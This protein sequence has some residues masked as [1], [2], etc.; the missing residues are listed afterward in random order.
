MKKGILVTFT[1]LLVVVTAAYYF[2]LFP[3]TL[4][5]NIVVNKIPKLHLEKG[6]KINLFN[7]FN[8]DEGDYSLYVIFTPEDSQYLGVS[9]VLYTDDKDIL[10]KA[11]SVL[12]TEYTGGDVATCDSYLY[13]MKEDTPVL[14]MGLSIHNNIGGL[15]SSEYGWIEF[16]DFNGVYNLLHQ[17][18]SVYTPILKI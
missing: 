11:Q 9:K 17:L 14:K 2:N 16:V 4:G 7:S 6:V 10:K 12:L 3:I 15:Q 5:G 13:L 8:F 18:S 1:I